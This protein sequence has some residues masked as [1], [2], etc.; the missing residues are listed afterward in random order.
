[1]TRFGLAECRSPEELGESTCRDTEGRRAVITRHIKSAQAPEPCPNNAI[2]VIVY[3]HASFYRLKIESRGSEI[4]P[5][6]FDLRYRQLCLFGQRE[7]DTIG[8]LPKHEKRA[9]PKTREADEMT[10]FRYASLAYTLGFWSQEVLAI[11]ERSPDREIARRACLTARLPGAYEFKNLDG[12]A[13][14]IAAV[15]SEARVTRNDEGS[16]YGQGGSFKPPYRSGM[17]SPYHLKLDKPML[18]LPT[19]H[20]PCEMGRTV[21]SFFIQRSRY[22]AFY[23]KTISVNLTTLRAAPDSDLSLP[24]R[25]EN[26]Y[27]TRMRVE[28]VETTANIESS[29][30]HL[31]ITLEGLENRE[32]EGQ[33]RIQELE[34]LIRTT[35]EE[36][37]RLEAQQ[38]EQRH[39]MK[40]E[41]DRLDTIIRTKRQEVDAQGREIQS[42]QQSMQR[43]NDGVQKEIEQKE[44]SLQRLTEIIRE[45][46]S[47]LVDHQSQASHL[48]AEIQ[49]LQSLQGELARDH[50]QR[51]ASAEA[52]SE[53]R[54]ELDKLSAAY[55]Q[56]KAQLEA[57]RNSKQESQLKKSEVELHERVQRIQVL[58]DS[59][60]SQEAKA[61]ELTGD[62]HKFTDEK[63]NL[64]LELTSA[65]AEIGD[66]MTEIR[67]KQSNLDQLTIQLGMVQSEI[68]DSS[69]ENQRKL[70]SIKE[71][72]YKIQEKQKTL[73]RLSDQKDKQRGTLDQLSAC[74]EIAT[75]SQSQSIQQ[76]TPLGNRPE[77][78]TKIRQRDMRILE[79]P[80]TGLIGPASVP[81][82]PA[83][84]TAPVASLRTNAEGAAAAKRNTTIQ[85]GPPGEGP[86]R[87]VEVE[88]REYRP[89]I[90]VS[91]KRADLTRRILRG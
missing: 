55:E 50:Q 54:G 80:A 30:S 51:E 77:Q 7:H 52:L 16:T 59:I 62:I 2:V 26:G 83:A 4:V 36:H 14:Q 15:F 37:R 74:I 5:D 57:E 27:D 43:Q 71:L 9:Q 24:L 6:Q 86:Q 90:G 91:S 28:N 84:P 88:F 78:P 1:M 21:S 41:A 64:S 35:E 23:G 69:G 58:N 11:L 20:A 34:M 82:A 66:I 45:A 79:Q 31:R 25:H 60:S 19:L 44:Q 89:G 12:C 48:L 85:L 47:S 33:S 76:A 38:A 18:F 73:D 13:D 61:A 81:A 63:K 32:R 70:A 56:T 49:R 42:N 39:E 22:L 8:Y 53:K 40:Q 87:E 75:E 46:E 72:E 17:P 3:N 29:A 67:T 10:M 65:R 68:L